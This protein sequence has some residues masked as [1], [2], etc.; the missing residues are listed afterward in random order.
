MLAGIL[1]LVEFEKKRALSV[2]KNAWR[3]AATKPSALAAV[4]EARSRRTFSVN[5]A[6]LGRAAFGLCK[7]KLSH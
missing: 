3:D 7:T 6:F 2:S 1:V 5:R 4:V